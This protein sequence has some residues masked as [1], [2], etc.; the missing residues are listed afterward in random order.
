MIRLEAVKKRFDVTDSSQNL[1]AFTI[2]RPPVRVFCFQADKQFNGTS[3]FSFF[4]LN[5][6]TKSE[7]HYDLRCILASNQLR[8][9]SGFVS[10]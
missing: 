4:S 6:D 7:S 10:C 1:I 8:T 9:Q 5:G 3:P 2:Q